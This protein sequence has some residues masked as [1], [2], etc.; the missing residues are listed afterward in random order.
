MSK[1]LN[2]KLMPGLAA[3]SAFDRIAASYDHLFTESLVGR[4]QRSAVWKVLLK[5]FHA[6]DNILEINCGTGEDALQLAAHGI[7]VFACD[8]SGEMIAQAEQRLQRNDPAPPVV[9]CHLPTERIGELE[10]AVR[11]DGA[12]SNFS[13]LN[14]IADLTPVAQDLSRLVKP[15][16]SLVL[17][18]STRYCFIETIYYSFRRRWDKAAR[19]WKGQSEAWLEGAPLTVYYPTLRQV[20]RSF[21]PHFRLHSIQGVG[22]ALPPSYL[23][24]WAQRHTSL[25]NVLARLE[26]VIS[27]WP[28]LRTT[29]DHMLLRFERVA[30]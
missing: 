6:N 5:T 29:G 9:F 26:G 17:C 20:R 28:I 18:L 1:P 27:T 25:F 13:G 21:A 23:E 24:P 16:G 2:L 12:F 10:P 14:C 15:E 30:S 22:V 19:R 4:A 3:G 8:A 7:S 11:F